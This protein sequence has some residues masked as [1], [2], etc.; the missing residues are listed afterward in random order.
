MALSFKESI[1]LE[2][3]VLELPP[4]DA[5][6]TDLHNCRKEKNLPLAKHA[7]LQILRNGLETNQSLGNFIV[8]MFVECGSMLDAQKVFAKLPQ[9]NEH[10]W[11][12]LIQGCVQYGEHESAL[13]LFKKMQQDSV[14]P[15]GY[16]Y[17]AL[18]KA[19]GHLKWAKEGHA[20]HLDIVKHGFEEEPF[21][22]DYILEMYAK[23]GSFAEA[24]RIFDGLVNQDLRLW[25]TLIVRYVE[26]GFYEEALSCLME[27][28][29]QSVSPNDV[30]LVCCLKACTALGYIDRGQCLHT[31]I[32][33][34]GFEEDIF[35]GNTLVDFYVNSGLLIEA[36]EV[37]DG[38]ST[39]DVVS[40]TALI[41]G[42]AEQE[43]GQEAL[44]CFESMLLE[45]MIPNFVTYFS[46]LKAC[47][48]IRAIDQGRALHI[49]TTKEGF[50][51]EYLVSST[52]IDLYSKCGQLVEARAVFDTLPARNV[53]LWTALITGYAEHGLAMEA[54]NCWRQ[55]QAEGI[56]ADAATFVCILK[57]CGSLGL[58]ECGFQV[59]L[60]VVI[61][62]YAQN[63]Y[64]GSTLV[65]MYARCG[66]FTEA[67]AALKEM[68]VHSVV[69]WTALMDGYTDHG[70]GQEALACYAEMQSEGLSP[71][72]HTFVCSLKASMVAD[73]IREGKNL[74]ISI[75]KCGIEKDA[76]VGCTLV[77][78][79]SK[80]GFL[81][82]A[83][84]T[85]NGLRA[86]DA[87]VW[88]S[89][90]IGCVACK[91]FERAL[92]Y[93]RQ[94][95]VE[96]VYPNTMTWNAL[97][98]GLSEHEEVA[99][100]IEFY[101]QMLDQGVIPDNLTYV[102]VL[103]A[104]GNS[105][106][107]ETGKYFHTQVE[108]LRRWCDVG[109]A[110][111]VIIATTLIDMYSKCG[112]MRDAQ[113]VC[114]NMSKRDLLAWATLIAGYARHGD[115]E[116]II[117]LIKAMGNEGLKPDEFISFNVLTACSHAGQV[118]KGTTFLEGM[119]VKYGTHPTVTHENC[120][121]DLLSRAG[122]VVEAVTILMEM[123]FQPDSITWNT[124]LAACHCYAEIDISQHAF[125]HVAYLDD[126]GGSAFV[127]MSNIY[128]DG[129]DDTTWLDQI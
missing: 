54:L 38:L 51:Q 103:K 58:I 116:C 108:N 49:A 117:G 109:E 110:G 79:Y 45:G 35:I 119:N 18:L 107:L 42:Y 21:V 91:D 67:R 112:C 31:Q 62:G 104:C 2:G 56:S 69:A 102:S 6:A 30:A 46:S 5:I 39:R 14:A 40:W 75:V 55:M 9:P 88:N 96:G 15:S 98:M 90:I 81:E 97:L 24:R 59:H 77:D 36:Q 12:S 123:S 86:R 47:V 118:M 71:N 95:Q 41:S 83:H 43:F 78:M 122:Q 57:V 114:D 50:E 115:C 27:M 23:C 126:N 11:T 128:A 22:S 94:M 3:S 32:I 61:E 8:P 76:F 121:I 65:D 120:A 33:Q 7:H 87:V 93:S 101:M 100:S 64:V 111:E 20:F 70:F 13:S 82:E 63:C 66:F 44:S 17:L 10:S 60:C 99:R 125:K 84:C 16:T 34:K 68:P 129:G 80:G 1:L 85:F 72:A 113:L 106:A 4:L 37:F 26:H 127:L 52:L 124:V 89:V 29:Q 53:V 74:H 92:S 19:C 25:T 73:S 28:Q 105:A 48:L